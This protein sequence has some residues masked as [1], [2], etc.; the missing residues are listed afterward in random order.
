MEKQINGL[1]HITVLASDPQQ[2]YDFYTKI[3][4]L[5]FIKKTVNFDAPDVYHLYYGDENGTPGT[6]LTFFPFPFAKRG[7]KGTGESTMVSFA[8]PKGSIDFW[9]ERLS[10]EDVYF[11]EPEYK[12]DY[13]YLSF[14]D[15][16]GFR[17]ELVEDD[18]GHLGGWE[19][20]EVPREYSIRKFFGTTVRLNNSTRTE[21][22]ITELFGFRQVDEVDTVKRY[23]SGGGDQAS[24]FDIII[25]PNGRRGIQSAGTVHHI[26]WRTSSDENQ[27]K[28]MNTLRSHGFHTTEIIDR[29][30]F[31]SIYFREPGGV[32]FEIA[33]DEPG[34]LIDEEKEALG[35]S[36]KLPKIYESRRA[37]I[38]RKLTPIRQRESLVAG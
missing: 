32:L 8:I 31:H 21:S 14:S 16:D 15:P 7:T 4:G 20:R 37:E 1:H 12:F 30:Y 22:L 33:T 2:N 13:P 26:A 23:L 25:D 6:I 3:L 9:I 24:R 29:N 5:R 11:D 19:S 34:F 28:W 10:R 38:E 36:L 17:L 35:R 18:V 27:R